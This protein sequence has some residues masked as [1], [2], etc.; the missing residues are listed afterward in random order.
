MG[1][2]GK[3]NRPDI[4]K[5]EKSGDV[6]GLIAA[7][8]DADVQVAAGEALVRLDDPIVTAALVSTLKDEDATTRKGAALALGAKRDAR[9]VEYLFDAM[10]TE[11]DPDVRSSMD[12][13]LHRISGIGEFLK[14]LD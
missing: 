10:D 9:A 8:G 11:Q 6:R 13:A 14:G 3:S 12:E 7:L 1:L 4:K 5:M 2:F